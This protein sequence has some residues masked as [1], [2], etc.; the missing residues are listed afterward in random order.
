[1]SRA[2]VRAVALT[3]ALSALDGYDVLSVTFAAPAI[4][5][6]WGVGK[7]A[8]GV[9]LSSGLAGMALGSFLLAPLADVF[10][11]RRMVLLSLLLMTIGSLLCAT[12]ATVAQL[13]MWRVCTGLGIGAC[14]AVIA[15]AAAEFSNA[16]WRSFSLAAMATGYPAG[17]LAGGL[18]AAALLR[19][20]GWPA[21]FVAGAAIGTAML[22]TVA[23]LL[24]ESPAFLLARGGSD[25][26]ARVNALLAKFDHSSLA[27]L[28]PTSPRV[29][30]YAGVFS[31]DRL[32]STARLAIVNILAAAVVYY[33]LSWL[34]QLVS[35]AGF[36]PSQGSLVSAT[37]S[38]FGIVGGL[39]M[40]SVARRYGPERLT[41]IAVSVLGV[42]LVAFGALPAALPVLLLAAGI[43]G[44]LIFATSAGFYAV[45][46]RG[47]DDASRASG[48]G[49]VIGTGRVASAVAPLGAGWL[50]AVGFERATVSVLF[51]GFAL[52]AGLALAFH[53]S[54]EREV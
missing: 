34:P 22:V 8:L 1:M 53:R 48:S 37:L 41:A 21:V 44:F 32:A 38:L 12:A 9:V 45:L 26:L 11:R 17:G 39:V 2:Q 47:F 5:H 35:E 24:P 14:V 18:L 40:G 16:R 10:G 50:F 28:P 30:G 19:S 36:T 4:S 51:G 13:A 27:E 52:L 29:R 25:A 23:A 42:V 54:T 7:V 6:D 20:S 33:V 43:L 31:A 49:F 15:P 46:A 3:V